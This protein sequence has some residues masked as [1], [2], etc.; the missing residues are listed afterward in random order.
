M[1]Q[2]PIGYLCRGRLLEISTEVTIS[3]DSANR[4]DSAIEI[5]DSMEDVLEELGGD[6]LE[7]YGEVDDVVDGFDIDEA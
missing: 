1:S 4:A 5:S 3:E 2:T 6:D 7:E